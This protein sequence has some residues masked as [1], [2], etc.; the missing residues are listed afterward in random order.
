MQN[1]YHSKINYLFIMYRIIH[2]VCSS[3]LGQVLYCTCVVILLEDTQN[4]QIVWYTQVQ[5]FQCF[6]I[7][8][9][10]FISSVD[11]HHCTRVEIQL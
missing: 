2:S 9:T 3:D 6:H 10:G 5:V 11:M 4:S 7:L 8:N 1:T